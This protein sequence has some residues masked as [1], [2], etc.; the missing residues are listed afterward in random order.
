[1]SKPDKPK[2][3]ESSKLARYRDFQLAKRGERIMSAAMPAMADLSTRRYRDVMAGRANADVNQGLGDLEFR[4]DPSRGDAVTLT[5]NRELVRKRSLSDSLSDAFTRAIG[6]EDTLKSNLI[7][8]GTQTQ[9]ATSLGMN[10][11][12]SADERVGLSKFDAK[13]LR[14]SSNLGAF[15]DVVNAGAGAYAYRKGLK[16]NNK[17]AQQGQD[18]APFAYWWS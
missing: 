3:P 8:S 17:K 10:D 2:E 16:S 14:R 6:V 1:M 13:L 9:A 18:P 5:G 4:S 15:S 12:A 7:A 11:L